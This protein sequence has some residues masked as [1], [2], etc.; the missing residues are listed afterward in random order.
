VNT[1]QSNRW[2]TISLLNLVLLAVAGSLLRTK[3]LFYMPYIDYRNLLSAHSHFAFGA[4][5]TLVLMLLMI[6][7]LL[8]VA[9]QQK[10]VYQALLWG[11]QIT[12]LGMLFTFPFQGYALFSIIFSTTYILTTYVFAWV[13]IAD[14]RKT[15]LDRHIKWFAAAALIFMAL[16]SFGPFRLAYMM[17]T[18]SGTVFQQK[19]AVYTFLHF[20]YNGFFTLAILALFFQDKY[21][22]A[23]Q[24]LKKWIHQFAVIVCIAVIPSLF[25]SLLWHGENQSVIRPIAYA[26]CALVVV[27][28]LAFFRLLPSL[29]QRARSTSKMATVFLAFA[30]FSFFVKMILQT[31]TIFPALGNAVFGFRPIIIGYLHQV[32]LGMV[33]FYILARYIEMNALPTRQPFTRFALL[34][35]ASMIVIHQVILLV[36]GLQLLS[37]SGNPVYGWLVWGAALGLLSG[38]L[39]LF[40]A[41]VIRERMTN[42][43]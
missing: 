1:K 36:N 6:R 41:R 12:S 17:A 4:W 29:H 2:I 32:F 28:L 15:G 11:I 38:A 16:S 19:D 20:Q 14:L 5:A 35:F 10:R 24:K 25:L 37:G 21:R 27:S 33:T 7:N 9:L 26:G 13:F 3:F 31:G 18:N 42:D 34:F 43:E 39:L 8:P 40:I 22:D 23:S 30:L